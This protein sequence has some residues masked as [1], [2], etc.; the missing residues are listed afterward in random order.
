MDLPKPGSPKK[1]GMKKAGKRQGYRGDTA[2]LQAKIRKYESEMENI[3]PLAPSSEAE[4]DSS[5][6]VS[7]GLL[8]SSDK[9][10]GKTQRVRQ[11]DRAFIERTANDGGIQTGILQLPHILQRRD[12]AGSH[13]RHIHGILHFLHRR[14]V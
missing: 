14:H 10:S 1:N 4:A 6:T 3:S 9:R 5:C 8:H 11:I 7:V 2:Q 12:A 13:D